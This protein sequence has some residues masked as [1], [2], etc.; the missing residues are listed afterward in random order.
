MY[1]TLPDEAHYSHQPKPD[2]AH[3][4]HQ[5]KLSN[6]VQATFDCLQNEIP[7]V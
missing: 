6:D 7:N 5:P 2:E 3:Y 1:G 4:S